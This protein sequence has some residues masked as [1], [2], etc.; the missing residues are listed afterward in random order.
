[1]KKIN[2]N[3][4]VKNNTI[5]LIVSA[6]CRK[7]IQGYQIQKFKKAKFDHELIHE[8]AKSSKKP[9]KGETCDEILLKN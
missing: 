1:L 9:S 6:G 4:I 8:K 7:F 2:T 5:V 3:F